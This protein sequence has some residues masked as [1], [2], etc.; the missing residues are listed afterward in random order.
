MS[1]LLHGPSS[2]IQKLSKFI[3]NYDLIV[4]R[5]GD[6]SNLE[7]SQENQQSWLIE[8][9]YYQANVTLHLVNYDQVD[10]FREEFEGIIMLPHSDQK[11]LGDGIYSL[12]HDSAD[13]D[14]GL[15]L[16]V[17]FT[18]DD[19]SLGPS[20][21]NHLLWA[22]DHG[23]EYI[24]INE[25]SLIES[26]S[27]RDK[28]GLPRVI[29]ALQ[30]VMWSTAQKKILPRPKS[31]A[32]AAIKP[33]LPP[34]TSTNSENTTQNTTLEPNSTNNDSFFSNLSRESTFDDDDEEDTKF[35]ELFAASLAEARSIREIALSGQL[36]DQERRARAAE[37]ARKFSDLL[38]LEG[39]SDED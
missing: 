5:K 30:S 7:E 15:R 22:V 38:Q 31:V 19:I 28:V 3:R 1:L 29:E 34:V 17:N 33:P 23:F 32:D 35:F 21:H 18:S 37:M 14:L 2:E 25:A 10:D 8:N 4:E 39:E 20:N 9:K 6:Q 36:S 11:N 16:L 13:R 26:H 24:E 12:G 27:D